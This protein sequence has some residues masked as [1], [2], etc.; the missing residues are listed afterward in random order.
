MQNVTTNTPVFL[1][2]KSTTELLLK[3]LFNISPITPYFSEFFLKGC[4]KS[5]SRF[6]IWGTFFL[7]TRKLLSNFTREILSNVNEND[8]ILYFYWGL[9]WSQI[10][11]F[12]PENRNFKIVVRFHGS[13]LYEELNKNYIPFRKEMLHRIN[14]VICISNAGK[15]YLISKYPFVGDKCIISRL[16][17]KDLGLN[18]YRQSHKVHIVSCSNL[19]SLKRVDLIAESLKYLTIPVKWTHLGGGTEMTRI[20]AIANSFLSTIEWNFP[21]A[22]P[23]LAIMDFYSQE[24]IDLFINVSSSEGVPVSVMEAISFGIPVIAT[25]VGGT[26]EIVNDKLGFL[27]KSHPD[28]EE[29]ARSI[30]AVIS[31]PE[32]SIYRLN[33][34]QQWETMCDAQM[35]FSKFV[36]YMETLSL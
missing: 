26:R 5:K 4:W 23:H 12:L 24:S 16:G 9:R 6:R 15:D 13:D 29:I 33:A 19:V 35:V 14:A 10:I 36:S 1:N 32:Y 11:P 2:Y 18:P 8:T 27:L 7:V 30:M 31:D 25:D 17:T 22:L 20:K 21:G 34:R 28:A 3:G